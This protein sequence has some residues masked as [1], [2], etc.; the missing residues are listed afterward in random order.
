MSFNRL[1]YDNCA[2]E[3]NVKESVGSLD[4]NIFT[5]KY[6]NCQDCAIGNYPTILSHEN[7]ADVE[8]ELFNLTRPN[9]KCP[10]NKYNRDSQYNNPDYTP[11]QL[12][13]NIYYITPNNLV[14]PTTNMLNTNNIKL[15]I[16]SNIEHFT[17]YVNMY[18]QGTVNNKNITE[19]TSSEYIND[20]N[21]K[22]INNIGECILIGNIPVSAINAMGG[23]DVPMNQKIWRSIC[24]PALSGSHLN[25]RYITSV[26]PLNY[27]NL[28]PSFDSKYLKITLLDS[29]D[30]KL[31]DNIDTI[32]M[33]TVY[34]IVIKFTL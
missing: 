22:N 15:D 24:S 34:S 18:F 2:Y 4:Y 28:Y 21:K 32:K 29:N 23:F 10:G 19:S 30:E 16:P 17:Q 6:E 1:T 7:R 13:Q 20:N 5:S 26:L 25:F 11:P 27:A 14:R 33:S 3:K 12:C 8:S 31:T 9:S